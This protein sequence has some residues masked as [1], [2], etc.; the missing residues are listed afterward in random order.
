MPTQVNTDGL[1]SL[2][3]MLSE[4]ERKKSLIGAA[5]TTGQILRRAA[6]RALS[7]SGVNNAQAL[8]KNVRL[9]VFKEKIGFKVYVTPRFRKAMHLNR[10]NLLKPVVFWLNGGT[11]AR[12]TKDGGGSPNSRRTARLR[13]SHKTGHITAMEFIKAARGNLPEAKEAFSGKVYEWAA[14]VAAQHYK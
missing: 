8:R 5:R 13:K 3:F 6:Q 4:R 1:N 7:A 2:W 10:H 11:K 12:V 14:R 9:N